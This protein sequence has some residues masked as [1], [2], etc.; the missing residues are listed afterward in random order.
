[1]TEELEQQLITLLSRLSYFNAAEGADYRREESER[2]KC[3]TELKDVAKRM[4]ELGQ[5]PLKILLSG[6]YLVQPSALGGQ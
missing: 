5:D 3:E 2:R 6:S 4:R 1:M